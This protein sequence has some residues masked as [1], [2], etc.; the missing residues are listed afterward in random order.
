MA[1]FDI[2]YLTLLIIYYYLGIPH[3]KRRP[4]YKRPPRPTHF[5]VDISSKFSPGLNKVASIQ[6][7]YV[8]KN[9]PSRMLPDINTTFELDLD[10]ECLD[11]ICMVSLIFSLTSKLIK[12]FCLITFFAG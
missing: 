8:I 9:R 2:I 5:D 10:K 3:T 11:C 12:R 6:R 1:Y 4:S 7:E